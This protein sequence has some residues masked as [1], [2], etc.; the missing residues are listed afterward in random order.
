MT[1]NEPEETNIITKFIGYDPVVKKQ[2]GASGGGYTFTIECSESEWESLR[3]V[4]S[5]SNSNR[6]I[7]VVLKAQKNPT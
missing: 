2:G 6:L 7:E 3:D 1:P 5:P 4:N